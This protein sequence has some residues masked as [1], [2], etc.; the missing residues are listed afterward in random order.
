[1]YGH[2]PLGYRADGE[3]L[4][5][6]EAE[7]AAVSEVARLRREGASLRAICAAMRAAGHRTKRGG[8]WRPS[9]VQAILRRVA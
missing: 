1:M 4:V 6:V 2:V 5:E 9:T 7:Q 8:V 3:A